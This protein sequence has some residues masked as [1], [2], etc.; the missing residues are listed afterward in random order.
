MPKRASVPFSALGGSLRKKI[1]LKVVD[2]STAR[3]L[4]EERNTKLATSPQFW[5][6]W[7]AQDDKNKTYCLERIRGMANRIT[8]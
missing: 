4:N 5:G 8:S 7:G 1:G 6:N 2:G 3:G